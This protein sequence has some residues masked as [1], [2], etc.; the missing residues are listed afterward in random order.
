VFAPSP[1]ALELHVQPFVEMPL[2]SNGSPARWNDL[3]YVGDRLF[4]V[5]EQD[6]RIYE[7]TNRQAV[8]WFDIKTSVQAN[9]G[10]ELDTSN[11]FHGGVRGIAFHPEFATNG[12]FYVSLMIQRPADP[13][14]FNYVSDASGISADSVLAEW[15]ANPATFEVDSASYRELFRVGVPQFDH[16]I[17]Q[18]T[19]NPAASVGSA[20]YG[21]L[22]IAHGDGSVESS[23]A[24][25]GQGNNALGKIL[26]INPLSQGGEPY[27]V[28][29]DN[30][31]ASDTSFPGEVYSYGHRNPHHLA[32]TNSGQLITADAGRDNID[33]INLVE[34]GADYGWS[35]REGD[36][37]LEAGTLVNGIQALP[38]DDASNGYVYPVIQFGHPG[39][40][41][42][43]F[44]GHALGGG[45][46]VENGS[47]LNGEYFY[48]DFVKSADLFHS[49]LADMQQATTSGQPSTLTVA[50]TY[51]SR[52][53][54]DHDS[55]PDTA[56]L[57]NDLQQIVTSAPGYVNTFDRVDVRIGQGPRG[58]LYLM[59]KRNNM[60]YLVTSSLPGGTA[61]AGAIPPTPTTPDPV[62]GAPGTGKPATASNTHGFFNWDL[63]SNA[64]QAVTPSDCLLS[65]GGDLNTSPVYCFSPFDRRL[66]RIEASG[67]I[68]WQFPLPGDNSTNHI[69]SIDYINGGTIATIAD[70]TPSFDDS[71]FD[72]STFDQ[73][74]SFIGT[75]PV[76]QDIE[77]PAGEP[78]AGVNLDGLDIIVRPGPF[79]RNP[80]P[81][82][83]PVWLNDMIVIGEYYSEIL[84][85]DPTLLSGWRNEGAF[86]EQLNSITGETIATELFPGQ[87]AGAITVQ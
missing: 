74:G 53:V 78:F 15:S 52:V 77:N 11:P 44:T 46:V 40:P 42:A 64:A 32:F 12:K 43:T 80:D 31:F 85:G 13:A 45:Y 57:D 3:D 14:L 9:T 28:P 30:P 16:P 86:R 22:Y 66:M 63:M 75:V 56:A 39:A 37:H 5:D 27:T 84:G 19:F 34:A 47:P 25:G 83:T 10:L 38:D 24:G 59:S 67:E 50:K 20:D 76:L 18:L 71:A 60:V 41:G 26:R 72:M 68:R 23:T 79:Y 6:G 8:L 87:S 1:S 36:V 62:A 21:L 17:K 69:E 55:N 70:A 65:A 81:N 4:V 2:A 61:D 58:E 35:E 7:I 51:L 54:F 73:G 29:A 82:G 33:E 49:S 48:I